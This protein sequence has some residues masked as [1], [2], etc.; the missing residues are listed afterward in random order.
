MQIKS[1]ELRGEADDRLNCLGWCSILG[2]VSMC[3][4]TAAVSDGGDLNYEVYYVGSRL[5]WLM[6]L[7]MIFRSGQVYRELWAVQPFVAEW[8][9]QFKN[10]GAYAG[11]VIAVVSLLQYL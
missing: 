9:Y 2:A 4:S 7:V 8:S 3:L 10:Y 1:F 5:Y 11:I 6:S